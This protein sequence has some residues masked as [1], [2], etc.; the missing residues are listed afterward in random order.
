MAV[1]LVLHNE[2]IDIFLFSFGLI[3]KLSFL[4]GFMSISGD[5]IKSTLGRDHEMLLLLSDDNYIN[6][7]LFVPPRSLENNITFLIATGC[8]KTP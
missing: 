4:C 2:R 8:V 6:H 3:F 1:I 5:I 7:V